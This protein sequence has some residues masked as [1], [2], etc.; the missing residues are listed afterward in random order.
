MTSTP[1][2]PAATADYRPWPTCTLSSSTANT[3]RPNGIC[4]GG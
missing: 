4:L 1:A 3:P 2:S